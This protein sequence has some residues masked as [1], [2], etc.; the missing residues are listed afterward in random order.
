MKQAAAMCVVVPKVG[1]I[2][3]SAAASLIG[4]AGADFRMEITDVFWISGRSFPLVR[5]ERF[6]GDTRVGDVLDLRSEDGTTRAVTVRTVEFVCTPGQV[7]SPVEALTLGIGDG[8]SRDEVR[9]GQVL[10]AR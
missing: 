2:A 8:L 10:S 3:R 9:Q 7:P 5:G 1:H 6:E 4:M